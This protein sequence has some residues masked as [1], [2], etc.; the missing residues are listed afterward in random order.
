MLFTQSLCAISLLASMVNAVAIMPQRPGQ[1]SLYSSYRG[2]VPPFPG[3]CTTP[4]KHGKHGID[5]LHGVES[6]NQSS[7]ISAGYPNTTY[8]RIQEIRNNEAG[9]LRIFQGEISE[10]SLKP[11]A[12]QYYIAFLTGLVQMAKLP[13]SQADTTAIAEVEMRH[14]AWSLIDIWKINPIAGPSDTAV[15]NGNQILDIT[16]QFIIPSSCPPQNPVYPS[17]RQNLPPLTAVAMGKSTLPWDTIVLN[18]TDPVNQPSFETGDK[19]WATFFHAV[20]NISVPIDMSE[21]PKKEIQ[22]TIPAEFGARGVIIAVVTDA[23][24]APT[25]KSVEVGPA[26]LLEQPEAIG[27]A[28]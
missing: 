11:I 25:L 12:C 5:D 2:K 28:F 17:P 21:W 1:S 20:A 10:T 6:F 16:N 3:N 19:F 26:I 18:F 14:E 15:P 24:G 23:I 7:F 8:D 4:V 9:H 22:V 27:S 13:A